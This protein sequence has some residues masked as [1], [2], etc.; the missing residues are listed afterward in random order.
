LQNFLL[1]LSFLVICMVIIY[2]VSNTHQWFPLPLVFP[3]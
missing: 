3:L 1:A 2:D